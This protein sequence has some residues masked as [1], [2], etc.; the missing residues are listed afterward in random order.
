MLFLMS[1]LGMNARCDGEHNVV[2]DFLNRYA[3][4]WEEILSSAFRSMMGR[5]SPM[6]RGLSVWHLLCLHF[7]QCVCVCAKCHVAYFSCS[8]FCFM[9]CSTSSIFSMRSSHVLLCTTM[10]SMSTVTVV[11]HVGKDIYHGSLEKYSDMLHLLPCCSLIP[12]HESYSYTSHVLKKSYTVLSWLV[13][14]S[15]STVVVCGQ[16]RNRRKEK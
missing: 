15:D 1:L 16:K 2:I 12:L 7:P 14:M 6:V 5:A 8:L 3:S 4:M 10:S 11:H 9:S 13:T